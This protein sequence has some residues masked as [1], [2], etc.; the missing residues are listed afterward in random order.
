MTKNEFI[1]QAMISM[2]GNKAH[3]NTSIHCV[4]SDATNVAKA[5][6]IMANAAQEAGA[7]F[8]VDV[9]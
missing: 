4:T 2:A 9:D 7:Y 1:L 3:F 5:A 6:R 8:D